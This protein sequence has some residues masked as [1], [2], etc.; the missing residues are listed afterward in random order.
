MDGILCEKLEPITKSNAVIIASI[1]PGNTSLS[2]VDTLSYASNFDP[3]PE[4]IEEDEMDQVISIFYALKVGVRLSILIPKMVNGFSKTNNKKFKDNLLQ[5]LQYCGLNANDKFAGFLI[6]FFTENIE[7]TKKISD[8]KAYALYFYHRLTASDL[9]KGRETSIFSRY[10]RNDKIFPQ[11]GKELYVL[12]C[13]M[14]VL[15][16]HFLSEDDFMKKVSVYFLNLKGDFGTLFNSDEQ[17]EQLKSFTLA[18]NGMDDLY[19]MWAVYH[20]KQ[21]LLLPLLLQESEVIYPPSN[22]KAIDYKKTPSEKSRSETILILDQL[23]PVEH[24]NEIKQQEIRHIK[25]MIESSKKS[26]SFNIGLESMMDGSYNHFFLKNLIEIQNGLLVSINRDNITVQDMVNIFLAYDLE[27]REYREYLSQNIPSKMFSKTKTPIN[28]SPS[29][30]VNLWDASK[31]TSIAY[32]TL[33]LEPFNKGIDSAIDFDILKD[34]IQS[35]FSK[36]DINSFSVSCI[37]DISQ[38]SGI[39]DRK[40]SSNTVVVVL[41]EKERS[42]FYL[43]V[44]CIKKLTTRLD[45]SVTLFYEI[46]ESGTYTEKRAKEN[47]VTVFNRTKRMMLPGSVD[48][49][50]FDDLGTEFHIFKPA[51]GVSNDIFRDYTYVF[52]VWYLDCLANGF[53]IQQLSVFKKIF[54]SN[55]ELYITGNYYTLGI[56]PFIPVAKKK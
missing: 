37:S 11:T 5:I 32:P 18:M 10:T 6:L 26:L 38:L 27:I 35:K 44:Y 7:L 41:L 13:L 23:V 49:R 9:H 1:C 55:L 17:L 40:F 20:I 14:F 12:R 31:I 56:V 15:T 28:L 47:V 8:L 52:L 45:L 22:V 51:V 54:G 43:T 25:S 16:S 19:A 34:T 33:D 36:F 48:T 53:E 50:F 42:S 2:D 46:G 39:E 24:T 30:N 3:Y 4:E 29:G 21:R